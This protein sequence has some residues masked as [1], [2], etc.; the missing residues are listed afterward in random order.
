M[1]EN[2]VWNLQSCKFTSAKAQGIPKIPKYS[3]PPIYQ[4]TKAR[5]EPW[6]SSDLGRAAIQKG[7]ARPNA[8]SASGW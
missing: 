7:P 4:S 5:H 1:F 8:A 2:T 6:L 3:Q